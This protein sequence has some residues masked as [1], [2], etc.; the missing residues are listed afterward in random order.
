MTAREQRKAGRSSLEAQ[1]LA[2]GQCKRSGR[3]VAAAL[4]AR[5]W[6]PQGL[7]RSSPE[8]GS[9]GASRSPQPFSGTSLQAGCPKARPLSARPLPPPLT[10]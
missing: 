4:P 8:P 7:P 3:R 10:C 1:G 9:T 5:L 2:G 6:F